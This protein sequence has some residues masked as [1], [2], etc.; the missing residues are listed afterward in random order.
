MIT[1]N[2][3]DYTKDNKSWIVGNFDPA[4]FKSEFEMGIHKHKAGE[5]GVIHFHKQSNEINI[6]LKGRM[7]VNGQELKSG[8]MF[9]ISP[10]MISEAYFDED[11]ALIVLRDKS[12]PGDKFEVK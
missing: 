3:K 7:R 6:I 11:T 2:I 10:Y 12:V 5:N 1:G 4:F 9:I 8:D